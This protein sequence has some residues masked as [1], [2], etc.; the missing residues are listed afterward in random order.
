MAALAIGYVVAVSAVMI[1]RGISV[2]PDYLLVLLVPVAVASGRLGRFL[3]DWVPFVALFLGWEAMRGIAPRTGFP[4]IVGGLASADRWLGGGRLPTAELQSLLTPVAGVVDN[5]ATVVYFCHFVLPV[6]VGLLLW[7]LD[8]RLF[9]RFVTALLGLAFACFVVYLLLPTA[10]PWYAQDHGAACCFRHV[11]GTTLPSAVSPYYQS[12]NPNP[13]AAF[14]SL[15]AAFPML[16]LLA[17]RALD[18]RLTWPALAWCLMVW[19]S[20]VYLGEHYLVDAA[21]GAAAAALAWTVVTR[22]VVPRVRSLRDVPA[23]TGG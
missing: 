14:P 10:P 12:I 13:V 23:S 6:A 1:W 22:L 5:A 15:H 3:G 4:P 7:L 17:L 20:I 2:S 19:F 21:A 9:L 16:G 11:I 8:R 18:R